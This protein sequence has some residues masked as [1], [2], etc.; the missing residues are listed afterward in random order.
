MI[1]IPFDGMNWVLGKIREFSVLGTKPFSF[2]GKISV[3]QIP[4]LSIGT[5]EVYSDGLAV[6]H[7]GESVVPA[8]VAKG[9]YKEQ[10]SKEKTQHIHIKLDTTLDG[11]VV[12]REIVDFVE[13][14]KT[15]KF[16]RERN[17]I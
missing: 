3:P 8:R 6:I 12:A 1:G 9:G 11:K 17:Y 10:Q 7:K 13:D 2:L 5:N 16:K 15:G 14:I 4:H